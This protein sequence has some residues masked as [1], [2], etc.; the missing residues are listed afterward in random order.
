MNLLYLLYF[1]LNEL[2]R[3]SD[4][5]LDTSILRY[6]E[7]DTSGKMWAKQAYYCHSKRTCQFDHALPRKTKL[8]NQYPIHFSISISI[9][10][11]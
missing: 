10:K 2:K 1:L 7:T 3:L 8:M 6:F 4:D 9:N 11:Y 5:S